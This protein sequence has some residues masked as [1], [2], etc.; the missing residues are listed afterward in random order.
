MNIASVLI[1]AQVVDSFLL[2]TFNKTFAIELVPSP[3]VLTWTNKD[4]LPFD[5]EGKQAL[6][7][8][9]SSDTELRL[10]NLA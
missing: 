7:I 9:Y 2:F 1:T 4:A 8:E 3:G 5:G 10:T 6:L